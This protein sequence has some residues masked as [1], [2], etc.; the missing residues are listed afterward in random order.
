MVGH[1]PSH[2]QCINYLRACGINTLEYYLQNSCKFLIGIIMFIPGNGGNRKMDI[3]AGTHR[4]WTFL[5]WIL[6]LET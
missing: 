5:F 6:W 3:M 1:H 4:N 2:F